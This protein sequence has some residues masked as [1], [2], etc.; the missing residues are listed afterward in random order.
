MARVRWSD[1]A[2]RDLAQILDFIAGRNPAAADR[3]QALFANAVKN[4]PD[5]PLIYRE[6]RIAGTREI[7]VHPNYFLVYRIASDA[8]WIV[9]IL[10]TARQYPP[11]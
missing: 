4:L 11:E 5:H 6:G 8:V 3:M 9:N 1:E 2:E 10:H 7:V